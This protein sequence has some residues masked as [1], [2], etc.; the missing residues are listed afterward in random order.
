MMKS[1]GVF[2]FSNVP[3]LMVDETTQLVQ[4][5]AIMR[6]VGKLALLYPEGDYIQAA[7]IDACMDQLMDIGVYSNITRF[8]GNLRDFDFFRQL[9]KQGYLL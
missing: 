3:V 8:P 4:S 5:P 6:Y 2:Q 9:K 1:D 7:Q